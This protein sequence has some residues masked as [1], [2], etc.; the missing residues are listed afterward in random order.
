MEIRLKTTNVAEFMKNEG[1][2]P[3]KVSFKVFVASTLSP[4]T[5]N[6]QVVM[7][8]RLH[9]G[10]YLEATPPGFSEA[11]VRFKFYASL[12]RNVVRP[13]MEYASQIFGGCSQIL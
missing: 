10:V 2:A 12:Y 13:C 1:R 6:F 9:E 4:E 8:E 7:G 11:V 3:G 5:T